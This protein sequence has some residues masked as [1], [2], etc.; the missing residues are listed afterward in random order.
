MLSWDLELWESPVIE[1][2]HREPLVP[3]AAAAEARGQGQGCLATRWVLCALLSPSPFLPAPQP[4]PSGL[5]ELLWGSLSLG[6]HGFS[7]IQSEEVSFAYNKHCH[8]YI[9]AFKT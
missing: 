4:G 9:I 6:Y 8:R 2:H 7:E 5:P 1:G 3:A